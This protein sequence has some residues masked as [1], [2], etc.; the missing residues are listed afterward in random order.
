MSECVTM[1]VNMSVHLHRE[2]SPRSEARPWVQFHHGPVC[3][4]RD[5]SWR[6]SLVEAGVLPVQEVLRRAERRM[7]APKMVRTGPSLHDA[8]RRS[9]SSANEGGAGRPSGTRKEGGTPRPPAQ[10]FTGRECCSS[11]KTVPRHTGVPPT[12]RSP[13]LFFSF[14]SFLKDYRLHRTWYEIQMNR[15]PGGRVWMDGW[16]VG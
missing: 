10:G 13:F 16:R 2:N 3:L 15:W 11:C 5:P 9:D 7:D 6:G 8:G 12:H 4:R 1:W 14:L